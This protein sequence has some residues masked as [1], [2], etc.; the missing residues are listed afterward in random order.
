[1]CAKAGDSLWLWELDDSF[2]IVAVILDS[3][4]TS[5][6]G[7]SPLCFKSIYDKHLCA[8][9]IAFSGVS[10][11]SCRAGASGTSYQD[12]VDMGRAPDSMPFR[13]GNSG[14]LYALSLRETARMNPCRQHSALW[15]P[16]GWLPS[17]LSSLPA[18]HPASFLGSPSQIECGILSPGL[19]FRGHYSREHSE[20]KTFRSLCIFLFHFG[21]KT[22]AMQ[23]WNANTFCLGPHPQE[24][25]ICHLKWF[26][27]INSQVSGY[28]GSARPESV[29][30]ARHS[31]LCRRATLCFWW[32]CCEV[33]MQVSGLF[34]RCSSTAG[35]LQGFFHCLLPS[36]SVSKALSWIVSMEDCFYRGGELLQLEDKAGFSYIQRRLLEGQRKKLQIQI[37]WDKPSEISDKGTSSQNSK[38][39]M[40]FSGSWSTEMLTH[41]HVQSRKFSPLPPELI[42]EWACISWPPWRDA[43]KRSQCLLDSRGPKLAKALWLWGRGRDWGLLRW[44]GRAITH[45]QVPWFVAISGS[46]QMDRQSLVSLLWW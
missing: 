33:L 21:S 45:A 2:K 3:L 18:H 28:F 20:G 29:G 41:P 12:G 37:H 22:S 13:W 46:P 11:A 16:M 6:L 39:L 19:C 26:E 1:M 5:P 36:V 10:L 9:G 32:G 25:A 42:R 4:P 38:K 40:F 30:W 35:S 23:D 43:G 27:K 8:L 17:H 14:I 15:C 24:P 31:N 34:S 44:R 7:L